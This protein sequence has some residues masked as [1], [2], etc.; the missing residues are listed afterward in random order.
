MM[1]LPDWARSALLG[2]TFGLAVSALNYYILARGLKK[3]EGREAKKAKNIVLSRYG[4][5]YILNIA[6]LFLVYRDTAM[7]IATAA[8]LTISNHILL[9]K[10]LS[11]KPNRKE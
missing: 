3:G 11:R 8:G 5:R 7:L 2:L 9:I 1:S 4:V 6:A 10:Y